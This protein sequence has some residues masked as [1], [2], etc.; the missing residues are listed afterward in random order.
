MCKIIHC[1][2]IGFLCC[3]LHPANKTGLHYDM[4]LFCVNSLHME[5]NQPHWDLCQ[6]ECET[7]A[8]LQ[9]THEMTQACM[10]RPGFTAPDTQQREAKVNQEA[11]RDSSTQTSAPSQRQM[12]SQSGRLLPPPLSASHATPL[13]L[14]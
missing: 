11:D 1:S 3:L 4:D 9:N 6:S 2:H 13:S 12:V 10:H 7:Y 8:A 14:P 5:D